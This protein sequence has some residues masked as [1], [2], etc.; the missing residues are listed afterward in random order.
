MGKIHAGIASDTLSCSWEKNKKYCPMPTTKT[1]AQYI[2]NKIS[3]AWTNH[4]PVLGTPYAC[5][6][7]RIS[8]TDTQYAPK[9]N[10]STG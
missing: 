3:S 8:D 6:Q 2:Q 4:G 5:M 7:F 10:P 9:N 1:I